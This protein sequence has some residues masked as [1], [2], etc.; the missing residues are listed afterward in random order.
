M[1]RCAE[2]SP[3]DLLHRRDSRMHVMG[4]SVAIGRQQV[5]SVAGSL[6]RGLEV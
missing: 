4:Y 1:T 6:E 5:A 3:R 2:I